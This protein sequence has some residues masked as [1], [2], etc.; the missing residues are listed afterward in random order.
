MR[1]ARRGGKMHRAEKGTS[2]SQLTG[3]VHPAMACVATL[4]TG[5]N[6]GE[7]GRPE[8][9]QGAE[10]KHGPR[11]ASFPGVIR[12]G[13]DGR[14]AVSAG[15]QQQDSGR[16]RRHLQC[17]A[18][19]DASELA[20]E[21]IEEAFVSPFQPRPRAKRPLEPAGGR[22][23]AVLKDGRGESLLRNSTR[24]LCYLRKNRIKRRTFFRTGRR[25][26]SRHLPWSP[27]TGRW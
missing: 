7:P 9:P 6:D 4:H 10:F 12:F 22:G 17:W 26:E 16:H 19:W 24:R 23:R 3:L 20:S 5:P 14:T 27:G 13:A 11:L 2:G 15:P 25:T 21:E 18:S 1:E 8:S